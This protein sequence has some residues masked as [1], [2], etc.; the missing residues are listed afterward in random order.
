MKLE[1]IELDEPAG[2][3]KVK[4]VV[5]QLLAFLKEQYNIPHSAPQ[6]PTPTIQNP[7]LNRMTVQTSSTPEAATWSNSADSEEI[8]SEVAVG[9]IKDENP[10]SPFVKIKRE[11]GWE[12]L[13]R[14]L[15][16]S[17]LV[18]QEGDARHEEEQA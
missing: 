17:E 11:H 12:L 4:A 14:G 15:V 6:S 9:T 18:K 2:K 8:E 13:G 1:E 5:K 10:D 3:G 7:N 16:E